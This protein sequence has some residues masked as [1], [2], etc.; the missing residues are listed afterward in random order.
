MSLGHTESGGSVLRPHRKLTEGHAVAQKEAEVPPVTL[1]VNEESHRH[2]ESQLKL[3]E[4]PAETLNV[5]SISHGC[6]ER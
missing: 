4:G 6:M 1:K 5:D 2:T 3:T